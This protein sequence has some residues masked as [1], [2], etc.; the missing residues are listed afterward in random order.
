MYL[1]Y[2]KLKSVARNDEPGGVC[3]GVVLWDPQLQ[4][5]E[6]NRY[7]NSYYNSY[8][9]RYYCLYVHLQLNY[10]NVTVALSYV[11]LCYP[12]CIAE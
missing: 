6:Y 4:L 5:L 10:L 12:S 8:Y 1:F 9:N 3:S 7:Y 11:M 2:I